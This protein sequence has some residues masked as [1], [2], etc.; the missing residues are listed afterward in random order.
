MSLKDP[1][2]WESRWQALD[3]TIADTV[4]LLDERIRL[5]EELPEKR[6][7][8]TIRST[9][10]CLRAF[11]E[12]QF[13]F[14]YDGFQGQEK[15]L[16]DSPKYKAEYAMRLTLDQIAFDLSVLQRAHSQRH[17]QLS[18][19]RERD[20]LERGD[21][22]ANLALRPAV[23][24]K[25]L[26]PAAVITY[27]Q[28]APH[29]RVV[30][31]APVAM[32]GIPYTCTG[33]FDA[34]GNSITGTARDYLAIAHE[35]GHHVYW[36]GKT[37]NV[38]LRASLHS[39]LPAEPTYRIAWL[40]EI[41]AD[42]YGAVVAGP[43]LALDFQEMLYDDMALEVDDGK[44]PMGLLRPF[45]YTE[46]FR[47]MTTGAAKNDVPEK[48]KAQWNDLMKKRGKPDLFVR[49]VGDSPEPYQDVKHTLTTTIES[50]L[51]EIEPVLGIA[52]I[53]Q[54]SDVGEEPDLAAYETFKEKN[55]ELDSNYVKFEAVA[56]TGQEAVV[57]DDKTNTIKWTIGK[58]LVRW[59]PF[60]RK[61]K[62]NNLTLLPETWS[63][64]LDGGGWAVGGPETGTNPP[65]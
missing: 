6:A 15:T 28:K 38:P 12:S 47:L 60:F 5:L 33:I 24:A 4:K 8:I 23:E 45:I 3:T 34:N 17:P 20:A 36:H 18:S 13:R 51:N 11:G 53:S 9:L 10:Q 39:K 25:V 16:V 41:F 63:T 43:I 64:L 54:W 46:T 2:I 22:L 21:K 61:A 30:P 56:E 31:Y 19:K 49:K 59:F 48:L 40:E 32:I 55:L 35:V 65:G 1:A 26:T 29:V 7:A 44:H 37:N 50:I 42:V 14:F 58:P 57:F 52:S 62:E 27:F